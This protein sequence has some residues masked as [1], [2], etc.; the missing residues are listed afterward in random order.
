MYLVALNVKIFGCLGQTFDVSAKEKT[1]TH[2]FVNHLTKQ[3]FV[4]L[5]QESKR[6]F[7]LH[8]P[9]KNF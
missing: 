7:H 4:R 8:T 5:L 2:F 9:L 6:V 3:N 1:I